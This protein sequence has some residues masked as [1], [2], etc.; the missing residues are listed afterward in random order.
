MAERLARSL[1]RRTSEAPG[2]NIEA[3]FRQ[4]HVP[5]EGDGG[6]RPI[7]A[8]LQN[9][10]RDQTEP[11]DR[12][13]EPGP[14]GS[15]E[16]RAGPAAWRTC[17]P[18]PPASRRRSTQMI[19]AAA[20]DFEG[21][22]TGATVR[23]VQQ[24][25]GRPGHARC[26][27]R[28]SRTAIPSCGRSDREVPLADFAR[29]VRARRDHRQV[30]QGERRALRRPGSK[31]QWTWRVDS[32][33]ARGLSR[34]DT[35]ASSSG[36]RR[37]GTPSSR[38]AATLPSFTMA[39]TPLTLSGDAAT[40][41]F[42][43]NGTPVVS[44]QGV[45]APANVQWPGGGIGRTAITV[46][47]RR[48]RRVLRR[49][50][51]QPGSTVVQQ[52]GP[53]SFFRMLDAGSVLHQGDKVVASFVV[54]GREV[55]YQFNVGSLAEP[56]RASGAAGVPLP[57]RHLRRDAL[58]AVRQAARRSAISSRCPRPREFLDVWE[59]WLQGGISR[60]ALELAEA[61]Q[62]AFLR[63]P[64][65]RFWLGAE[66]CGGTTVAGAFMPSVDGVGR[67][68]PL[69]VFACAE[70]RAAIPPP[71]LD[72]QDA[73]FASRGGVSALGARAGQPRS[74]ALTRGARP[75]CPAS[76][77]RS[78]QAPPDGMTRLPDGTI[79][80]RSGARPLAGRLCGHPRR[81][82]HSRLCRGDR[83]VDDRRRG[84]PP[85]ALRRTAHAGSVRVHGHAHRHV[86]SGCSDEP[87]SPSIALD[88]RSRRSRPVRRRIPG[89]VREHNED[90][91]PLSLPE[92][93]RV[94]RGGR[95]GRA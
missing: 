50:L 20:N 81:G 13:D 40:A 34:P 61:W 94:G 89:K 30:L 65:W 91:L 53:W 36:R 68:F 88:A 64:I 31:Q 56:A 37:S 8:L 85:L 38:P 21:D 48:R 22:A 25:L 6:R 4:F 7:D 58:R 83:L 15:R 1:R 12:G 87:C 78:A 75:S 82:L 47:G 9:S 62:E 63:A 32:R 27:S 84:F 19:R 55:S 2:A 86:S 11:R 93:R 16:H 80:R 29:L 74:R 42:E 18:T 69:T 10:Q 23:T 59:T 57:G 70:A 76:R 17:A 35:C 52:D 90:Q 24:A 66:V 79:A 26:A 14:G 46:G 5:L 77:T 33:V 95:D 45:N 71:E 28:S 54:G 49:R 3:Q 51:L 60:A 41:K 39:V 72:P 67:Y 92:M 44:Q 73:W 43:I